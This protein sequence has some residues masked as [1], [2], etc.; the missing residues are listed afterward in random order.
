MEVMEETV[1][2]EVDQ[3]G[4]LEVEVPKQPTPGKKKRTSAF[5]L[6][7]CG[8][9]LRAIPRTCM[10]GARRVVAELSRQDFKGLAISPSFVLFLSCARMESL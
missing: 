2:E 6:N 8:I 1:K 9:S 5:S 4:N 3:G 7:T 10:Q